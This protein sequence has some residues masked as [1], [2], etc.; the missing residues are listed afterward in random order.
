MNV[1]SIPKEIVK[2]QFL[3]LAL[4][5]LILSIYSLIYRIEYI[6][7][8]FLTFV[9]FYLCFLVNIFFVKVVYRN[10]LKNT[11]RWLE[12]TILFVLTAIWVWII[13]G[14]KLNF[15]SY[16]EL[17]KTNWYLLLEA[18]TAIGALIIACYQYKINQLLARYEYMPSV[19]FA[20][21][22]GKTQHTKQQNQKELTAEEKLKTYLLVKNNSKF[23]IYFW[24][25]VVSGIKYKDGNNSKKEEI[26]ENSWR[27][28]PGES[29]KGHDSH[30]ILYKTILNKEPQEVNLD[31]KTLREKLG[32]IKEITGITKVS[33]APLLDKNLKFSIDE[34][35]WKFDSSKLTWKDSRGTEDINI[36]YFPELF[37]K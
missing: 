17:E 27:M 33:Y 21:M 13:V 34:E 37:K 35:E 23:P 29:L 31:G 30:N 15:F 18:V 2:N 8:A 3:V 1:E 4:A 14:S 19:G 36:H 16:S 11:K 6:N 26:F 10:N 24:I 5:A 28:N 22:S 25:K 20:L 12:F 7:H 9:Y 32:N